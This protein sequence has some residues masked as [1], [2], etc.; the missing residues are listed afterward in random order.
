MRAIIQR[1]QQASVAVDDTVVSSIGQGILVLLGVTHE[2]DDETVAYLARKVAGLR[3]FEDEAGK[4]NLALADIGGEVLV[5]SQFTLYGDV[6][7]GRRPSFVAAAQPEVA[8]A[9]YEAFCEHLSALG[10]PV[11]RG[12]FQAH[13]AVALVND[14]PVTLWLDTATLMNA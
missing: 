11:Q 14:G 10:L 13:M 12:V 1:V 9:H 6:R 5:V 2:D 8:V 7:K 3:I 4:L